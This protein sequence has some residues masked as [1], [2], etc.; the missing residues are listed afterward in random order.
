MGN[1]NSK[2]NKNIR[3][4][5]SIRRVGG[6]EK[7]LTPSPNTLAQALGLRLPP[8]SIWF[9]GIYHW[10]DKKYHKRPRYGSIIPSKI[11]T[12][13]VISKERVYQW[14]NE[15]GI[16]AWGQKFCRCRSTGTKENLNRRCMGLDDTFLINQGEGEVDR[17]QSEILY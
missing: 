14:H 7:P 13:D 4:E 5:Q 6:M 17:G 15:A 16:L 12:F 2:Y 1:I 11:E 10:Q 8:S 9:S 3:E